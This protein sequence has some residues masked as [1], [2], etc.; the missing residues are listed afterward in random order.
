VVTVRGVVGLR[1]TRV[2]AARAHVEEGALPSERWQLLDAK[3]RWG[4]F[5]GTISLSPGWNNLYM[6][7]WADGHRQWRPVLVG[8][9]EVFLVAGQSNAAGSA[10]TLFLADHNV[11]TGSLTPDGQIS[12]GPGDDPQMAGTGGSVWPEVGRRLS[13]QLGVPVAFVNVAV[14]ST[15]IKDWNPDGPLARR[16]LAALDA[17]QPQAVRAILWHQGESDGGTAT[18]DYL[19][20][21]SAL[22]GSTAA[23]TGARPVRWMVSTVSFDGERSHPQLRAAQQQVCSSGLA[24]PGPDTDSIGPEGRDDTRVHFNQAGTRRAAELWYQHLAATYF[25]SPPST[26]ALATPYR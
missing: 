5:Q 26:A 14:G 22:I 7:S 8:V 25:G 13:A 6:R 4:S 19:R 12:W 20:G 17:L 24:D 1:A 16:L 2:E 3:P 21:L 18:E 9:G 15:S 10:N 11:R 23:H